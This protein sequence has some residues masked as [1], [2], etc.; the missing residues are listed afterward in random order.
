MPS[1][2]ALLDAG[3]IEV[4]GVVTNPDRPAGR[5]MELRPSPV[6][7]AAVASGLEVMQPDKARD[8]EL[9]EWLRGTG[10]D[11]ATVVAYGKILPAHLLEIP[12]LG[13]V[14]VHFSL[15]P[16]YRGAAPV[17]QALIDGRMETG[18]SIMVLTEGMDE[19]P[20]IAAESLPV[21]EDETAGEVGEKLSVIGAALLVSALRG[22]AD[23]SL[24]PVEQEH[25]A[26]TYAGKISPDDARIDWA[27]PSKQIRDLVRGCNPIP[28]AWTT[29][30]G[31]RL[32]VHRVKPTGTQDIPPGAA[33]ADDSIFAGAGDGTLEL[34]EVQLEG[35]RR[36]PGTELARGLRLDP[37]A[38]FE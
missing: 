20:V 7:Q 18:V 9:A 34:V 11:V 4:D 12:R 15:L 8:P 36:M 35:R 16:L 38:R 24:E 6:K 14:N 32:K 3:D 23:G 37:N 27:T 29:L 26:A 5:G 33:V 21:G 13:F 30:D 19:G 2:Q 1:L 22:Y 25:A 28:G 31:K 17:Q 10:A